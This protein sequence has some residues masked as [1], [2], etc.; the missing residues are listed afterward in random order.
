MDGLLLDTEG[1]Y[2]VVQQRL[3]QKFGKEFTWALKARM[4]GLK[5]IEAARVLVDELE[6]Q[7]QL[8]PEQFLADR[9]EALDEMFP[10][11]QLLPG[12][13]RLL[14]HLA[15]CGVP[16]CLAT[17][18]HLR[19]FTLKTTLHGELFELFNHRVT[20]GRDQ[21]SSGKPAPDIFLHAAGLWQPAP[22]PSCC[23]V[24]EDAP[25]GVAAAKAAGMR[26]VMVPDPNLDRALCGGADLVLDSLEQFQ[27][28][29]W[30]LPP[31][32]AE[33]YSTPSIAIE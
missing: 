20:G 3:A 10:T 9:E 2:T 29:A 19:H 33:R 7:G 1:M 16:M 30:G 25:S 21:I 17:S 12:A 26:C 15:A 5:A 13:E 18:S 32:P 14:R 6:L 27:P 22:D 11:A 8:T 24:L 23:L 31:F 4:M 28:Q